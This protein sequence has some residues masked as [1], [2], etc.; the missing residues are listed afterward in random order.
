M[1]QNPQ[2]LSLRLSRLE[3]EAIARGVPASFARKVTLPV[4]R[5]VE[6]ST[7]HWGP[8]RLESY[9]WGVLRR[10]AFSRRGGSEAVR[11]LLLRASGPS[12]PVVGSRTSNQVSM[13]V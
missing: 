5:R 1:D 2:E 3:S 11:L 9:Y 4:R 8:S 7:E 12:G 6:C 13:P 10:Q